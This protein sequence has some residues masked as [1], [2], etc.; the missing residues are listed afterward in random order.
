MRV[1][2]NP[3]VHY[4]SAGFNPG[5]Q[6]VILKRFFRKDP[7]LETAE[8]LFATAADRARAPI[9]YAEMGVPDTVEGRFEM[10]ALHVW[11][12]LRRL[13]G[14]EPGTRTVAQ[15]L[16]DVMFASFDDALR[17]LGVGDLVVGKK[18]RKLAENFYG[19]AQA[20]DG[21][22]KESDEALAKALA[23]NVYE[24]GDAGIAVRLAGYVRRAAR[25]ID[26]QAP[27]DIAGGLVLFP[28]VAT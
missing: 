20:Y 5:L 18:V 8:K 15:K 17:E 26:D 7:A 28:E 6:A 12:V 13:K 24:S 16:F 14:K 19:R 9:F 11:L 22:L 21:A 4:G 1:A 27:A 10:T 3:V 23:R 2:A 25:S